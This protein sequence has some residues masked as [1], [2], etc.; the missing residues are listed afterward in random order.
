MATAGLYPVASLA[1]AALAYGTADSLH[2]SGFLAVY[3]AGVML[4]SATL[5]AERTI[6]S[7][8][9]GLGWVAQVAMFLTGAAG[10]PVAA[11]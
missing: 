7:F 11:C 2:G 3:L 5:P 9:E 10:V 6:V 1:I 8:H 4:G